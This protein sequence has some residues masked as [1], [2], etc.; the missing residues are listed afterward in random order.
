[1]LFVDTHLNLFDEYQENPQVVVGRRGAGKTAFLETAYFVH[2]N[3]LIVPIDKGQALSQVV[4]TVNGIP[5][6]GRFPEAVA[7]LWDTVIMTAIL[8]T[9]V[10]KYED[11][12][13]TRDYLAKIGAQLS[14]SADTVAWTLLN[15]IRDTQ[16]GKTV[17]TIAELIG[18]LH[19]VSFHDAKQELFDVL[20]NRKSQV[21]VLFDSLESEGYV[22]EDP[23]TVSALKGLLK[24]VGDTGS[25]K[26]PIQ[27]RFCVPGEY[28]QEFLEISS[29]PL[30]DFAHCSILSWKTRD[31][32]TIAAN[33]F[34]MYRTFSH[35][36]DSHGLAQLD[37]SIPKN[38]VAFI[39][40][41]LPAV[42]V[43]DSED[44]ILY[45]LRHTQLLPRQ[46][47]IILNTLFSKRQA[48][49]RVTEVQLQEDVREAAQII[50]SE[51]FGAY[52][53][54]YPR[55][56]RICTKVL[57]NLSETLR[58]GDLHKAFNRFA[59]RE[60]EELQDFVE[61]LFQIGAVG[62]VVGTSTRYIK[63][64]FQYNFGAPLVAYSNEQLCIHP[65]FHAM[66]SRDSQSSVSRVWPVGVGA[67][68]S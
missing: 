63:G 9:A 31:L 33:R 56:S 50:V 7:G 16:K 48:Q 47:F 67:G 66:F 36:K 60:F 46:L 1:M 45:I 49:E 26:N 10:H 4:M 11:L 13:V 54:R 15:T 27:P 43:R 62:R 24:W 8:Q 3:D 21:L 22:F 61:M 35:P 38:A 44:I 28:Y 32:I 55:A 6:G 51:V 52:N 40:E 29:N 20:R 41:H 37:L 25:S 5:Q 64:Q 17:A 68:D 18:R 53:H 39:S 30:K 57:P 19:N 59:K 42:K 2:P 58:F 23:D 34:R 12:R 65:V 14:A